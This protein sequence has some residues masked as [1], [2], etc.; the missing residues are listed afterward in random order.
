MSEAD[1]DVRR[2]DADVLRPIL[3][4]GNWCRRDELDGVPI[5]DG[6]RLD[7][8]WPD[9]TREDVLV[10]V[11]ATNSTISDMGHPYELNERSVYVVIDYHGARGKIRILG[12]RAAR[13]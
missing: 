6:E 9:G 11:E 4:G 10:T 7:L 13:R 2:A 12:M 8:E 5:Q 1:R 3:S